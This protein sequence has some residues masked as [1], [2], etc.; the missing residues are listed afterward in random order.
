MCDTSHV[1]VSSPINVSFCF[2]LQREV[3]PVAVVTSCGCNTTTVS[4]Y[5]FDTVQ[6]P[7]QAVM[8]Y[9]WIFRFA[10]YRIL[11]LLGF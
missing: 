9:K 10:E 7:H 4:C 3:G 5:V 2:V 11:L 6:Y 8:F 1:L